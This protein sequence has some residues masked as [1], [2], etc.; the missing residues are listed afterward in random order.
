MNE[1]STK[2]E[3][4]D[5]VCDHCGGE[6][7]RR[8]GDQPCLQ[9]QRCRCQW[10]ID[11]RPLRAGN[12]LVCLKMRRQLAVRHP[13]RRQLG[14]A[15]LVAAVFFSLVLLIGGLALVEQ[16]LPGMLGAIASLSVLNFGRRQ[17]WW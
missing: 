7:M 1:T 8:P 2:W 5:T 9:C 14:V 13:A 10:S 11:G 16:V 3:A 17:Q 6:I 12:Q 15:A 4:V